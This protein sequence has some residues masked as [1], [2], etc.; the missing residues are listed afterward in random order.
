M[1]PKRPRLLRKLLLFPIHWRSRLIVPPKG[2]TLGIDA[3]IVIFSLGHVPRQN[4]VRSAFRRA[5]FI[6]PA[7]V[8]ANGRVHAT[9]LRNEH[10]KEWD[11][12]AGPS[13]PFRKPPIP[14][15]SKTHSSRALRKDRWRNG[16][17]PGAFLQWLFDEGCMGFA[18][19]YQDDGRWTWSDTPPW[20]SR[21]TA[22]NI[23]AAFTAA[24]WA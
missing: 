16:G 19:Y 10:R 5:T 11:N 4:R 12:L 6:S 14:P 13:G 1:A 20:D 22:D 9:R 24:E 17:P 3:Q 18:V 15:V 8:P 23:W 21:P 7:A 2:N